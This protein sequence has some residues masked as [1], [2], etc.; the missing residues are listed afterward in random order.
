MLLF[1]SF[2]IK[3][4]FISFICIPFHGR[5]HFISSCGIPFP[6]RPVVFH[7]NPILYIS[8][9][10]CSGDIGAET[11]E[12]IHSGVKLMFISFISIPFHGRVHFITLM[13]IS[14]GVIR[15]MVVFISFHPV[16]FHFMP[17]LWCPI[18]IQY[19]IYPFKFV[20]GTSA[21]GP[22]R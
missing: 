1:I 19:S 3:I 20:L 17:V 11:P 2:G 21:L 22:R 18:S 16:A 4:M 6:A 13:F 12:Q 7:F 5:V 8:S 15:F 9:Q 10:V 14:F